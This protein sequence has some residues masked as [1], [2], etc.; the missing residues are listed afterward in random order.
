MSRNGHLNIQIIE[1]TFVQLGPFEVGDSFGDERPDSDTEMEGAGG[2]DVSTVRSPLS[3]HEPAEALIDLTAP[4]AVF[5][6][7]NLNDPAPVQSA[8]D[9]K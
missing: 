4:L 6:R 7:P 9:V 1:L 2:E 8:E 5:D 3:G